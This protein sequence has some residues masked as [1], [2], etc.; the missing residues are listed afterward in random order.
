MSQKKSKNIILSVMLVI[1]NI[2][3]PTLRAFTTSI[4]NNEF[5]QKGAEYFA[6]CNH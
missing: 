3:I 1:T 5:F 4:Y 2:Y 6:M